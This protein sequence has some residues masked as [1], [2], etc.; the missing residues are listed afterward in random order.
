MRPTKITQREETVD[1]ESVTVS[2]LSGGAAKGA[3]SAE[4]SSKRPRYTR[5][6]RRRVGWSG[7][8]HSQ[9]GPGSRVSFN[10]ARSVCVLSE[11]EAILLKKFE[12][13]PCRNHRH[14]KRDEAI[15]MVRMHT[16]ARID[17]RR[18]VVRKPLEWRRE[19]S[20]CSRVMQ[21]LP[22]GR[23]RKKSPFTVSES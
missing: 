5:L 18:I 8:H 13:I 16:A 7:I 17:A 2:V 12:P 19:W 9:A 1:G 11:E 14:L 4:K 6:S 10:F 21:L 22:V 3:E 20:D 15:Q 23:R